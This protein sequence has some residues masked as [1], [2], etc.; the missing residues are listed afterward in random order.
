[1]PLPKKKIASKSSKSGASGAKKAP[2]AKPARSSKSKSAVKKPAASK[3]SAAV[4]KAASKKASAKLKT[5]TTNKK[6]STNRPGSKSQG[7]AGKK[8]GGKGLAAKKPVQ[9]KL[10]NS[11]P[12]ISKPVIHSS[13]VKVDKTTPKPTDSKKELPAELPKSGAKP[14]SKIV[15]S[16]AV[17]R[18]KK[19]HESGLAESYSQGLAK[20]AQKK[21]G[22]RDIEALT[23]RARLKNLL[24]DIWHEDIDLDSDIFGETDQFSSYYTDKEEEIE[25]ADDEDEEWEEFEEDES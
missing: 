7:T 16:T 12:E 23:E 2:V 8:H 14:V 5:A 11:Q 9:K 1:V 15:A 4:A 3:K 19:S 13:Q 20:Q 21:R 18:R 6:V 10:S 22:W 25:V 24:S 17:T